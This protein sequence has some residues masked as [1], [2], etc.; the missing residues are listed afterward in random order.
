MK[1]THLKITWEVL[2]FI[3]I[4]SPDIIVPDV[5]PFDVI[6]VI[7]ESFEVAFKQFSAKVSLVY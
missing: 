3:V 1:Q 7:I 2:T 6:E 5:V 4:Q